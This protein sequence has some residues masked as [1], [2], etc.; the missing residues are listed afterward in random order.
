MNDSELNALLDTWTVP[1][2]PSLS[3]KIMMQILADQ[4]F[5]FLFWKV[6]AVL[7]VTFFFGGFFGFESGISE[8]NATEY[9]NSMF[10]D[11]MG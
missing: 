2:T 3:D 4:K 8:A 10:L 9:F 1:E 5:C 6:M 7:S 11:Y